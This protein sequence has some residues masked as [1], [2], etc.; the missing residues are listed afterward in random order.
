MFH[1]IWVVVSYPD[2]SLNICCLNHEEENRERV[3]RKKKSRWGSER[4]SQLIQ[5]IP[6]TPA[7]AVAGRSGLAAPGV[8]TNVQLGQGAI[9]KPLHPGTNLQAIQTFDIVFR[10]HHFHSQIMVFS[11]VYS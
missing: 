2:L 10:C 5:S 1:N 8:V 6:V 9:V 3:R 4:D 11:S 7:A